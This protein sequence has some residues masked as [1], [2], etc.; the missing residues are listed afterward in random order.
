MPKTVYQAQAQLNT[1]RGVAMTAWTPYL[2]L[3]VGDPEA[4]GVEI[5]GQSY[6]RQ[7]VVFGAPSANLMANTNLI[8]FPNPSGTWGELTHTALVDAASG[9]NRRQ[10]YQLAGTPE[11]RTVAVGTKAP[12]FAPG[13]VL[14]SET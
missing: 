13:T 4:G 2:A 6:A 14:Y 10:V 12:S 1:A 11:Q 5:S 8:Q 9:G 7:V 3:Y